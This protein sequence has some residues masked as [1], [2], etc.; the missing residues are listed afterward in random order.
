MRM[1]PLLEPTGGLSLVPLLILGYLAE[2]ITAAPSS[3][4][5]SRGGWSQEQRP[6]LFEQHHNGDIE[7]VGERMQQEGKKLNGRFLHITDLHPDPYYKPYSSTSGD[8]A[9]HSGSGAAGY[10]GAETSD[11]DSP[12]TLINAT[13]DWIKRSGLAS[14]ID[15]IVWTGDSARHDN[16]ESI[17]RN[18]SQVI[19]QNTLIVEK[20]RE[21]F[22]THPSSSSSSNDPTTPDFRLPI[23]PTFGNN[24]ILPHNIFL[25]G[26]NRWTR[27]YASL[28]QPF[29]PE[30]QRHAF[31]QVGSF[32]AEVIP[33]HLAVF[34]LNTLYFFAKNAGVD[35]CANPDEP[36]A[37][38]FE[39]LRVRLQLLRERGMKAI[40]TGHVPPAR[41][42][43]KQQWDET[44]WQRYALWLRQ[45]RDVV[46]AGLWGHMN[47][48]HFMLQDFQQ[49]EWEVAAA[50]GGDGYRD[51]MMKRHRSADDDNGVVTI[52]STE[53]YLKDLRKQWSKLPTPPG[54]LRR[55]EDACEA[56]L[57]ISDDAR[58]KWEIDNFAQQARRLSER[59]SKEEQKKRDDFFEKVGGKWHERYGVS[60]VSPSVVPNFFP[61]LRVF[62]Y[63]TTGLENRDAFDANGKTWLARAE[64]E[65]QR[66]ELDQE[67]ADEDDEG[68]DEAG[69]GLAISKKKHKKPKK[70]KKKP[71]KPKFP[72]PAPP[73]KS[74]PPGPAY[75][76][77]S[78]TLL[79]YTQYFANLTEIN[80]DFHNDSL[81]GKVG[82]WFGSI[83]TE[84]NND[85]H[86]TSL[87]GL[88][89][90]GAVEVL[91][92]VGHWL[93]SILGYTQYFANLTETN[94]DF[95]N[96]S[97]SWKVG[98]W[99]G[100]TLKWKEGKHHDKKPTKSRPQPKEFEYQVE[101]DTR[102]D[103]VYKLRDL[104]VG[105]WVRLARRIGRK[106]KLD[107]AGVVNGE[108]IHEPGQDVM[109]AK[110]GDVQE[111]GDSIEVQKKHKHK[112]KK[113]KHHKKKHGK[114]KVWHAF[115][116]R[117]FVS[118]MSPDDIDDTYG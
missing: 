93:G 57:S 102:Q 112:G 84:I 34:S 111:Q 39:W 42:E 116:Q 91:G 16:D 12:I 52:A 73:S 14:E 68:K 44:C 17:P 89:E 60:L 118:T 9:C 100:S 15:F 110:L 45:Y 35:G 83:L 27:H 30:E 77:Q 37:Q 87:L 103:K 58:P 53:D 92:R 48:E 74:A 26:P 109:E 6:L 49:I 105:E 38:T 108:D 10:Y 21:V 75:S 98:Y 65:L 95:H 81:S 3:L 78:L 101:Y 29:I 33:D 1:R 94:N 113:K 76:P 79:G 106:G 13:F 2:S 115:I 8:N 50:A 41:T 55:E 18:E 96:A 97:R 117:A 47:V 11:C 114:N 67:N 82:H 69:D 80:N 70:G 88:L 107:L 24:D 28:W 36:G 51:G 56:L 7:E 71:P 43:S 59:T 20:F 86:D 32:Y 54:S 25:D 40:I 61:T 5:F 46:V 72:L 64:A 31:E 23:V 63:N 4:S 90:A 104:T 19:S 85:F 62:E 99:L 66:R 22:G